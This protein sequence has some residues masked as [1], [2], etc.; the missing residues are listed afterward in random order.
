MA[1]RYS[2]EDFLKFKVIDCKK[3]FEIANHYRQDIKSTSLYQDWYIVRRSASLVILIF[4]KSSIVLR[5][6]LRVGLFKVNC[7]KKMFVLFKGVDIILQIVT[8]NCFYVND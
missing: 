2:Y 4:M 7:R 6:T 3:I 1:S 5:K 8:R